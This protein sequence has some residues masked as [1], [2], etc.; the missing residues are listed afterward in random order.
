MLKKMIC[1]IIL[2][3]VMMFTILFQGA[4]LNVYAA[5]T[6]REVSARVTSFKILE[7]LFGLLTLSIYQWIGMQAEMEQT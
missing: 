3:V 2:S 4:G 7:Y 6:P 5:G 1:R